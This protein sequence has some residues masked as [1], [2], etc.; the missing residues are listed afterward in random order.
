M[1][2]AESANFAQ[3]TSLNK[4]SFAAVPSGK[5]GKGKSKDVENGNGNHQP[6]ADKSFYENLPFHG[7]KSPP[8]QVNLVVKS[9]GTFFI[10]ILRS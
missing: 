3:R 9:L 5:S 2:L 4:K 1:T 7:L 8:K 6:S 10:R